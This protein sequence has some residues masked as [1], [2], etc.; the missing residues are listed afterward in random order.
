LTHTAY[1]TDIPKGTT[2]P[3][4]TSISDLNTIPSN[5]SPQGSEAVGP[6]ANQ[7]IQ[8]HAAF[9][10]QI[11]NGG[12][13]LPLSPLNMNGQKATNA[14]QGTVSSSSTDFITG[15]QLVK[16]TGRFGE[17]RMWGGAA[18]QA[19]VAA[20]WG[21]GWFI[22]DG[23]NGTLDLRDKF[24]VAAGLNYAFGTQ[25]GVATYSLSVSQMPT[26]SHAI[27]DPGHTHGINDAGH[28][29]S[30]NDPGH[31]HAYG[32]V[33]LVVG[34]SY[35]QEGTNARLFSQTGPTT[36]AS[37]TF[38]SNNPALANVSA[39]AAL[40]GITGTGTAGGGGLIEN[41]PPFFGLVFIMYTGAGL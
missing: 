22:A 20:A 16:Y 7:Y 10:K 40:T 5:N 8:A 15:A 27:G 3:V 34:S 36:L 37:Q 11:A 28:N 32:G 13:I 24:I 39:A 25:G 23:T 38:V 14:A 33:G 12:A 2:M 26:H 21:P 17:I 6:N 29:H 31:G 9:I 41:R 30:I 1:F 35:A 4:P 19:A 18:T